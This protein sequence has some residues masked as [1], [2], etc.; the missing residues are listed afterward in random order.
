MRLA[1]GAAEICGEV[2]SGAASAA[3]R[4]APRG[5]EPKESM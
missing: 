3:M 4:A 5:V 1:A 2:G